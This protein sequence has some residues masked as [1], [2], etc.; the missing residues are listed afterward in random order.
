MITDAWDIINEPFND[1]GTWRSDV[2]FNTLGESFVAIALE[3]ASAA[4]PDAKL[5]V[6][7]SAFF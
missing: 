2:F 7:I 3:D 5:Y 4:D 1:D 6:S